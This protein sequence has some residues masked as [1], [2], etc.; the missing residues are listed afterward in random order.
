LKYN[1]FV[2]KK[3]VGLVMFEVQMFAQMEKSKCAG[4][5]NGT[6]LLG[7]VNRLCQNNIW[8][9]LVAKILVT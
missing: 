4:H 9:A 5:I 6:S 8:C 7:V 2:S 3:I 1:N